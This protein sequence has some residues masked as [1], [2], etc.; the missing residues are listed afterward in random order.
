MRRCRQCS[1]PA[2]L[3]SCSPAPAAD[4]R[5]SAGAAVAVAAAAADS[6]GGV[7]RRRR[8]GRRRLR[9]R[10]DPRDR[11]LRA[12][13]GAQ[14][15]AHGAPR[16]PAPRRARRARAP[17]ERRGRAGRRG[18]R[19]GAR[20]G[21]RGDA[22]H[23]D[24]G[25][26]GRR[27]R[28]ARWPRSSATTCSSNGAGAL[29]DFARK[30]WRNRVRVLA[31]PHGRLRRARQPRAG[32]RGP[33]GRARHRDARGLRR[34][35]R[36]ADHAQRRQ[37]RDGDGQRVLDARPS[38]TGTG[39]CVSIE[40]DAEGAHHLDAQIVTSPWDDARVRDAAVVEGALA[41]AAL[42]GTAT[43]ELIDVDLAAD[44]RAQ[45][46]DL[47]LV[48]ARFAPDV[49]EVAARRA[50]E[51]WAEAVDGD[52]APLEAV[53][54]PEAVSALLYGGD[55]AQHR[56]LVVRGPRIEQLR[57]RAHRRAAEPG[58]DDGAPARARPALRR[59]P[60]HRRA[61]VRLTR[62]RDGVHRALDD[63]AGTATATTALAAGRR[64]LTR[65]AR[66]P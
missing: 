34:G 51:A 6:G 9:A 31:G 1:L 4:R 64:G 33:R 41:G 38:A 55:P 26:L 15:L 28:R 16:S 66:Q 61:G 29:Q 57:D 8:R 7:L 21:R 43:A 37:R 32:R 36:H 20:R 54:T 25:G 23:D 18:V 13:Q 14:H 53:A 30:G 45:A 19:A 10:L 27:R 48:D 49:L 40:R 3:T 56:R 42:P 60:R 47:S 2:M 59:G 52:D 44:A 22:V 24:P 17:G 50:A 62:S 12:V 46:L 5:A 39:S 63:G 65:G 11:R 35:R 58:A